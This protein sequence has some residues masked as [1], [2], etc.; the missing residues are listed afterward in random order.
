MAIVDFDGATALKQAAK[1]QVD[2]AFIKQHCHRVTTAID[3]M[4]DW[5]SA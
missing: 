2:E 4:A 5:A 3:R 1:A